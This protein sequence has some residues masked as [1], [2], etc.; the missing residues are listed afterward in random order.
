[1]KNKI[2][3][4]FFIVSLINAKA[5]DT[6]A[7]KE[8]NH[9]FLY[10]IYIG[11]FYSPKITGKGIFD[12]QKK[13][14]YSFAGGVLC[15]IN[16]KLFVKVNMG[17]SKFN[18][19]FHYS[20]NDYEDTVIY[21]IKNIRLNIGAYLIYNFINKKKFAIHSQLGSN[22]LYGSLNDIHID[23]MNHYPPTMPKQGGSPYNYS[24]EFGIGFNYYIKKNNIIILN[25]IYD[26]YILKNYLLP[27]YDDSYINKSVITL[28][29]S[30]YFNF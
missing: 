13:L 12:N 4:L 25:C 6:L 3:I 1:M 19:H 20:F 26:S 30:Y 27:L 9:K 16:D 29:L 18:Y 28:N 10:G 21:S 22:L 8:K 2:L 5:Q 17:Y 11:A 7:I 24:L 14:C 23:K 15:K